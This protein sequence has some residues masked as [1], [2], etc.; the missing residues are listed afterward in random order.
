MTCLG[1]K[2]HIYIVRTLSVPDY[3]SCENEDCRLVAYDA[4]RCVGRSCDPP[5]TLRV[6]NPI[7]LTCSLQNGMRRLSRTCQAFHLETRFFH[8]PRVPE[9]MCIIDLRC[10]VE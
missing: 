7:L 5:D 8:A 3:L 2:S 6:S 4:S 10:K 1:E 9:P